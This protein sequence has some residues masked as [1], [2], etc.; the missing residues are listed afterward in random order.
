MNNFSPLGF[1]TV[2]VAATTTTANVALN[3]PAA[4]MAVDVR[5][6]NA[7][8]V[9]ARVAFGLSGVAATATSMPLAPGAVEKFGLSPAAT[10]MAA[11]TDTG[12]ATVHAT[13]G[14]GR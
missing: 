1:A 14:M 11:I 4:P 6:Y 10:H 9:L 12:T 13:V 3:L 5:L 2:T 7:G 8:T